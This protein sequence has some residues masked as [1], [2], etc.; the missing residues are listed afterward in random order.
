MM[1]FV[2]AAAPAWSAAAAEPAGTMK[3]SVPDVVLVDQNGARVRVP[4]LVAGR[5]VV[6]NFVFTSCTT[7]CSPMGAQFGEL[8]KHVGPDVRLISVTI[9][10]GT[11]TPARLKK[12]SAQF[13]AGPQWTL[14]TGDADDVERLLKSLGVYTPNRFNH[15]PVLLVGDAAGG[16]WLRANGLA[17]A[18]DVVAM[19]RRVG[20]M[21]TARTTAS[22]ERTRR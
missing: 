12:W 3:L 16:R 20:S 11:D 7:I 9:D 10:P 18:A 19:I 6:M 14:L 2:L 15:G 8:Q 5:V 21:T 4:D 1:L 17:P 22:G 13:H